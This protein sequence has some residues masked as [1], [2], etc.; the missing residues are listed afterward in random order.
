MFQANV[1]VRHANL[2]A[3]RQFRKGQRRRVTRMTILTSGK[4][5]RHM[6]AQDQVQMYRQ[7]RPP[8]ST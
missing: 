8:P 4:L 6:Q 5:N 3:A 1:L 7:V 2:I